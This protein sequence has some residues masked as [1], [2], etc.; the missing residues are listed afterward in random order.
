MAEDLGCLR[1]SI[2]KNVL[3]IALVSLT[4]KCVL[5]IIQRKDNYN[6]SHYVVQIVKT[7]IITY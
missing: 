3:L 5:F 7:Q 2:T 4:L 1:L 6:G